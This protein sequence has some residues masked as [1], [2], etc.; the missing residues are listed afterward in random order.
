MAETGAGTSF[1][2]SAGDRAG[3]D[4]EIFFKQLRRNPHVNRLA[5]D[6][7]QR[8]DATTSARGWYGWC[9]CLRGSDG[10]QTGQLERMRLPFT[11][12]Q[13]F[14]VFGVFNTALWPVL[15]ALWMAS[16]WVTL[17]LIRGHANSISITV[18]AAAHWA[19]TGVA[20][21]AWYFSRIN[22]AAWLFAAL[23]VIQAG[24]LLWEG[25]LHRRLVFD[26]A[27]APRHVVA[28]IFLMYSFLYPLFVITSH[29]LPRAPIYAVPCPTVLFTTGLVFA[30]RPPVRRGLL[31]V[32][33][34]W[35]LIGSSAA[36]L[37]GMTPDL[38]LLPG[39]A[40][41]LVY[42]ARPGTIGQTASRSGTRREDGERL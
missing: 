16:C 27:G 14:D 28:A 15:I 12:Q 42:A 26:W 32:P 9:R 31:I 8:P 25:V 30:A 3:S 39:A 35:S 19:W 18:V 41:L 7:W 17:R 5:D 40:L 36:I 38:M 21:H 1:G 33:I 6:A 37:L 29:A 13:F 22:P 4:G 24:G 20:Y 11:E 2:R 10:R 34:V 23:F